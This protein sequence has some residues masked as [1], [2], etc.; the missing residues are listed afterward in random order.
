MPRITIS[1]PEQIAEKAGARAEQQSR[2]VS[3]YVSLLIGEDLKAAGLLPSQSAD[4]H[5]AFIAKVEAAAK[6]APTRKKIERVLTSGT[7][8][9]LTP[10]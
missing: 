1:V 5:A 10:V 8:R 7:R 6:H 2:S 9:R 4:D 3:S